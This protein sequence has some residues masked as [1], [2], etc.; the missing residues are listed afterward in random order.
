M[1]HSPAVHIKRPPA[2]QIIGSAATELLGIATVSWLVPQVAIYS[3]WFL[4]FPEHGPLP[5][6][7]R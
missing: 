2:M 3:W 5:W 4:S 6:L 1:E 7:L